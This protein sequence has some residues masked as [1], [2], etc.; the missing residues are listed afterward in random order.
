MTLKQKISEALM[1]L[2]A[3]WLLYGVFCTLYTKEFSISKITFTYVFALAGP[4][5]GLFSLWYSSVGIL[6]FAAVYYFLVVKM[7]PK[8]RVPLSLALLLGWLYFG[9]FCFSVA[10]GGA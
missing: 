4:F 5:V 8:Y 10:S 2:V 9:L 3:S 7:S 1:V 6:A